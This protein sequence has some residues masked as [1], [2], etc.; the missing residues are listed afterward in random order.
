[1]KRKLPKKCFRKAVKYIKKRKITPFLQFYKR[2]CEK[3]KA[4]SCHDYRKR[5]TVRWEKQKK[6]KVYNREKVFLQSILTNF[7]KQVKTVLFEQKRA[8]S[9]PPWKQESTLFRIWHNGFENACLYNYTQ[10]LQNKCFAD[11]AHENLL[12]HLR[13]AK[14][15]PAFWKTPPQ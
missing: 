13:V 11:T 3:K 10:T 1:M 2:C 4:N 14:N 9:T 12:K 8:K 7:W 15:V 5:A 6:G